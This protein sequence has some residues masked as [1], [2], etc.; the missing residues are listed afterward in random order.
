MTDPLVSVVDELVDGQVA[1][2]HVLDEGLQ[3]LV[4]A[5]DGTLRIAGRDGKDGRDGVD[6]EPGPP[7]RDG[8]DAATIFVD[9]TRFERRREDRSSKGVKWIILG[10]A[11]AGTPDR[12]RGWY[13]QR[14]SIAPGTGLVVEVSV[15]GMTSWSERAN[16]E[17]TVSGALTA[18]FRAAIIDAPTML[19][20]TEEAAAAGSLPANDA[21]ALRRLLTTRADDLTRYVEGWSPEPA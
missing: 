13:L 3:A 12:G 9:S 1:T 8:S 17:Y 15:S 2:V 10:R 19:Q 21:L 6:G 11:L 14:I 16:A 4:R 20:W 7:G 5:F 18:A